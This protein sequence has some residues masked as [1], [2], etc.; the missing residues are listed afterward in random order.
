MVCFFYLL[1]VF[2]LVH[3]EYIST[4]SPC[5]KSFHKINNREK[6]VAVPDIF[7]H[8]SGNAG[9]AGQNESE[10]LHYLLIVLWGFLRK[11]C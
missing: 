9:I 7:S 10:T 5:F 2:L 3:I 11:C 4:F 6:I 1:F 8:L